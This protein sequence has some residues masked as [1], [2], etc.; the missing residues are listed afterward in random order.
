MD[1]MN[2]VSVAVWAIGEAAKLAAASGMKPDE[3][4]AEVKKQIA[5][6]LSTVNAQRAAELAAL[7]G[8]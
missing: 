2:I 5:G 7:G 1:W 3:F 4:D 6:R 8:K